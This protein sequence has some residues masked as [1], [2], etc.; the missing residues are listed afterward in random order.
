VTATL[1]GGHPWIC[2]AER[3]VSRQLYEGIR[4]LRSERGGGAGI[5][6]GQCSQGMDLS[7]GELIVR[8]V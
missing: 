4:E 2:G 5:S 8:P 3:G 6:F 1:P 7:R